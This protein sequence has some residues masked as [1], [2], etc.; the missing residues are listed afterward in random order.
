MHSFKIN[1]WRWYLEDPALLQPW[2]D[3]FK[4]FISAGKVKS[5]SERDV[6]RVESGGKEYFVKYSRPESSLQKVRSRIRPKLASE[7]A[8]A[9]LLKAAG[10]P[11]A[12]VLG[13][14]VSGSES[15]LITEAV[16][17][18]DTLR[19][20]WFALGGDDEKQTAAAE[21]NKG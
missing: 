4:S 12:N 1:G 15:M 5:N 19:H 8:S 9:E 21:L 10:I 14:G 2:F 11:T 3:D 13:W 17:P 6:F 16:T 20:Y 7:F 18:S